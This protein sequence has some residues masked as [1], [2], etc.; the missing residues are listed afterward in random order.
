MVFHD[1]SA[2]QVAWCRRPE[3][4]T[5]KRLGEERECERGKK[6]EKKKGGAKKVKKGGKAG[7][8]MSTSFCPKKKKRRAAVQNTVMQFPLWMAPLVMHRYDTS[9]YFQSKLRCRN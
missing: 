3:Q 4:E 2:H 6:G 1:G 5:F 9:F 7:N 8:R